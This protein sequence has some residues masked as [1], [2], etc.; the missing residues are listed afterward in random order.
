VGYL[1]DSGGEDGNRTRLNG[2]A[3][4]IAELKINHIRQN[5]QHYLL[6]AEDFITSGIPSSCGP[7]YDPGNSTA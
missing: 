1:F 5:L 4:R 3:G 7:G 2:F 6:A